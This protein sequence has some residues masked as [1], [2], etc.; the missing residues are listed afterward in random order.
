VKR[1]PDVGDLEEETL[2]S[3][4]MT[5]AFRTER[6]CVFGEGVLDGTPTQWARHRSQRRQEDSLGGDTEAGW[7]AVAEHDAE[8]CCA[9][10]AAV[11]AGPL[12]IVLA[13]VETLERPAGDSQGAGGSGKGQTTRYHAPGEAFKLGAIRAPQPL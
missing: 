1:S 7:E 5:G 11:E 4:R 9:N 6:A 13:H 10:V 12:G 3:H 2:R 8:G